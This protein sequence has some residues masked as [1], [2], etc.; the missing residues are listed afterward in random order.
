MKISE[1][2]INRPV[3]ATMMIA[4]LLVLGWFSYTDLTVDLLPEMDFP[5]VVVTTIYP[6]ASPETVESQVTK[7]IEDVVNQISGV[8]HLESRSRE[9][10]SLVVVEFELDID[11]TM[12]AQDVREKVAG[13][14]SDLPEHIEEP[15][16]S[17]WDMDAEAIM[18]IT[19]GGQRPPRD[20]TQLVK[21]KIIPRLESISGVGTINLIGGEEREILVSLDPD[22]LAAHE[23]SITDVSQAVMAANL[24]VPGGRINE[25]SREYLV[26]V[27]GRLDVPSRFSDIIVKNVEGTP[28]FLSDVA[29]VRDTIAEQRSL[30][31][32][33]G[34]AAVAIEIVKQSGANVV[35]LAG[36]VRAELDRLRAELPPD[37][38]VTVVNDNSTFIEDSISEIL[39]NIRFG[40]FLA[41]LVIFLFLLDF[42]P[43]IITGLSIPISIVAT[44]TIMKFL[45]FTINMMTLLGLSLA[46]GLLIDDSIV[47]VE[48]I[49][50]RIH[51]GETPLQAAFSGTKEIGLAVMATTFSIVVVFLPVAFMSGI[52]GRFFYQFGM[53]VAF[54][55]LISLFVAF[56]LV[57][58]L[59]A[60]TSPPEES[61]EA[62]DPSRARGLKHLWLTIRRPISIWNRAFEDFKPTYR[63]MLAYSLNHRWLIVLVATV[64]FAGSL[65]I[66]TFLGTEFM[67]STDQGKFFVNVTTPPGTDLEG[68]SAR[69]AQI[70]GVLSGFNEVTGL[71]VTIGSGSSEVTDGSVLVL[72][73]D[74][75]ERKLSSFEII[76]STRH[77][78]ATVPGIKFSVS[79]EQHAG[80]GG[81]SVELSIRGEDRD[82]LVR[83][84]RRVQTILA[85]IP[86]TTDVD[87][88]LEEGK[89]EFQVDVDRRAA[90][91]LGVNLAE[92]A[93]TIRTL[94]EGDVVTRYEE[95]DEEYDV[96]LRL[97]G[98]FRDSE[99]DLGRVLIR[100]GKEIPGVRTFLVPLNRIATIQKESSIGEYLRY[101]RLPE[102]RVDA[103]VLTGAFAGTVASEA[104][105]AVDSTIQLP[106]GYVVKPVGQAEIMTESF[107]NIYRALIL[108]V[109]FI[110]LLLASQ[111]E[112][113]WDP[114][115]IMLSLPLSLV[116]A[117]LGLLA[118]N[119][120]ISIMSLVG[121][122]ML[123][124]LVTKNAI[125][126]ID[127]VKQRRRAGE[128]RTQAILEAGPI[129]L[130]PILMTTFAM[131][132]GMLPLALGI[133]AGAEFR[134]PMA[135]A[136]IGGVISSTLLTLVVV[137]VVYTI[138]DDFV[139][140]FRRK[141]LI[142]A[143]P[144]R[145]VTVDVKGVNPGQHD[146]A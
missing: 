83:L 98:E 48:N 67:T 20:I 27:E 56:S 94:I 10:Y 80:P 26:R 76:D 127:F 144:E 105:A 59:A 109:V 112:S 115:S 133:G 22:R 44:F 74:Q 11:G 45:G 73:K 13:I 37:I 4:A 88:S 113:F 3:F 84:T 125:L 135:R 25:S 79:S 124:G 92:L 28:V 120:S 86:G 90:D 108:A 101:D 103:N 100:S 19:I 121:V 140:M 82:E 107:T 57:P 21:D 97:A 118:F 41:V 58:M 61:P 18:S 36:K 34:E 17:Q 106:P 143:T 68:T 2:S 81:K 102:V 35:E 132:F 46:V 139:G 53:T 42:R 114:F 24:E 70:E 123:M 49:F 75:S 119:S 7:E 72:L 130:R 145:V 62:L 43:T 29:A 89:P 23:V 138:I 32:F 65:F 99:A 122:V 12:A 31:R 146:V 71:Y 6:G 64:A 33:N 16:V 137:P 136:V 14:R 96:R 5:F 54:A 91:D 116:G 78:V 39:F 104:Q 142:P 77:L 134:A 110:Y 117:V 126:L 50:R 8:R 131:V 85:D 63:R 87:N 9:G 111:Y 38:V 52:V 60:R 95:G 47:V 30:S 93:Q 55:V 15:V 51:M 128:D 66:A 129:R 69:L 1:I 40:T 141:K